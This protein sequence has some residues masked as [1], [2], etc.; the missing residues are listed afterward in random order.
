[1]ALYCDGV[2]ANSIALLDAV[3][4]LTAEAA[5]RLARARSQARRRLVP[6]PQR[7]QGRMDALLCGAAA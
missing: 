7:W 1:V 5:A 6:E 4:P 3:P 2:L